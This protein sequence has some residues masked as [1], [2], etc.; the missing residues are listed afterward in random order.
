MHEAGLRTPNNGTR[1]TDRDRIYQKY[2][3]YTKIGPTK[4][5]GRVYNNG[6]M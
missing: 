3:D 6:T 5:L 1:S 2:R 4:A